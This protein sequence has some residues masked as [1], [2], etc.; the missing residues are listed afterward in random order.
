MITAFAGQ[1]QQRPSPREGGLFKVD[2]ID[3]VDSAPIGGQPVGGWDLAASKGKK[4]P[5]SVRVKMKR[6]RGVLYIL[7]VDRRRT[8]PL[9]LEEMVEATLA[10]PD[11][12]ED[13]PQDPGQAGKAQKMRFAELLSGKRFSIT[14]ETGDK[15]SRAQ[16]FASQIEAGMVKLVKGPWNEPYKDELRGFPSGTYKDQVDASSRAYSCVLR[17]DRSEEAMPAAPQILEPSDFSAA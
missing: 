12:F 4:S 1:Y 11:V 6:L 3:I 7:N 2:N 8:T 5:Y 14:P 17:L 15:E 13:L 16:P 9:E 10:E